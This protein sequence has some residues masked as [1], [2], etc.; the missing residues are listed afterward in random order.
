MSKCINQS[1]FER[2]ARFVINVIA[3]DDTMIK[4]SIKLISLSVHFLLMVY[5]AM[6]L[7]L[8]QKEESFRLAASR[9]WYIKYM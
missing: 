6:R 1:R 4:F 2:Y 9:Y 5:E 8:Q 3:R 7:V